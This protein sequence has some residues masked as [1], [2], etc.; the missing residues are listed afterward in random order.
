[1]KQ[2]KPQFLKKWTYAP[3]SLLLVVSKIKKTIPNQ[4]EECLDQKGSGFCVNFSMDSCLVQLKDFILRGTDEGFHTERILFDLQN[5]FDT[6]DH[7]VLLQKMACIGFKES[8]IKWF[9]SYLKQKIFLALE[10]VFLDAGLINCGVPQGSILGLL[11]FL[12]YINDLPQAL[13]K[14]GLY[15]YADN[16]CIFYQDKNIEKIEKILNKEF[17]SLCEWFIDYKLSIHFGDDKTKTIF[18]SQM[19]SQPK[20]SIL[21][22]DYSLKQR[23]TV[24]Y[25]GCYLDSN[26]NEESMAS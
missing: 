10:N 6:L 14:I 12:I 24:E 9:Q 1:M 19:K 8:V 16:T 13:N 25:L 18:F 21:Y 7:T 2:Q 22:G 26:L 20:L 11:L 5:T 23:N 3:F 4:T 15:L 17:L